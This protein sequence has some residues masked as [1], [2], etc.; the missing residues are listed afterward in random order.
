MTFA[1]R[2]NVMKVFI[3]LQFDYCPLVW[4]FCERQTN[5][6]IRHIHERVLRGVY[7]D[8]IS[9]LEELLVRDTSEA[10][11][12]RNIKI[13]AAGLFKIISNMI[14]KRNSVG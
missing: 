11:H 4:M 10:I 12:Q 7:N 2:R 13:L 3:K 8:E 14:C 9:P 5:A 6:R 1:Q